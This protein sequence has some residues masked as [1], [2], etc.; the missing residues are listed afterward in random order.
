MYNTPILI[1]S[2]ITSIENVLLPPIMA[3]YFLRNETTA[4]ETDSSVWVS[5]ENMDTFDVKLR[6]RVPEQEIRYVL[7]LCDVCVMCV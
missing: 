3:N 6:V 1:G 4:F 2:N 5:G 7:D